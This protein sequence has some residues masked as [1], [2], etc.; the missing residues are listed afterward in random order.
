[1][2]GKQL[3]SIPVTA[4]SNGSL[5]IQGNELSAGIYLAMIVSENGITSN[6]IKMVL[7]N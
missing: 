3:K 2:E 6:T 4:S 1:M 5:L 7:I